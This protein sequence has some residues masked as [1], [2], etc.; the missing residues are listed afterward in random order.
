M[1][2]ETFYVVGLMLHQGT[3]LKK[4][5]WNVKFDFLL[6]KLKKFITF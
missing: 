4:K 1:H 3:V 6:S 2:D 5:N